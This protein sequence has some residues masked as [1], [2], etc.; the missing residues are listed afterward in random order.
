MT[1]YTI[2]TTKRV[3]VVTSQ[4]DPTADAV[5]TEL[6]RRG[7]PV[8]RC[9]IAQFPLELS[10]T[11]EL[12]E[13]WTGSLRTKH[14]NVRLDEISAAYYR[15]PTRFQ[16]PPDLAG[17]E[18]DWA[19]QQARLGLGGVFATMAGWINHPHRMGFAEYKPV[20]LSAAKQAGFSMPRTLISNDPVTVRAFA[21]KVGPII[22]K[23]FASGGI[24]DAENPRAV[25]TTLVDPD[26][27]DDSVRLTAHL[28]Q[29]KVHKAYEVR[30][31]VVDHRFFAA[32]IT[33]ASTAAQLD[34]RTDYEA[35]RYDVIEVPSLIK[36]QV[37]ALM[38]ELGLRFGA[39][40]F[41]VTPEGDWVFFEINPNG[42]WG[43][44]AHRTGLPIC[45]AIVDALQNDAQAG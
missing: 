28:F 29:E 14:R 25:Y 23:P 21:E 19:G 6:A 20:Q 4:F 1:R 36:N 18:L 3:L 31:T 12:G 16:F 40:D 33:A 27:L 43:W 11:A 45:E 35:L 8:F 24:G 9:D 39:L 37:S 30:L 13:T 38:S 42:Q 15:R 34:W 32:R 17:A 10:I 41:A 2:T 26:E 22:Y 7:N 44:I 5:V